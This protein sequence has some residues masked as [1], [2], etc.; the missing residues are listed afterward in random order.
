MGWARV[1]GATLSAT[2][3]TGAS[4]NLGNLG[5]TPAAGDTVLAVIGVSTIFAAGQY[6]VTSIADSGGHT[7]VLDLRRQKTYGTSYH[8]GLEVWRTVANGSAINSFTPTFSGSLTAV[9]GCAVAAG[10]YSGVDTTASAGGAVDISLAADG[11]GASSPADSGTTGSTT[12]AANELKIGAYSDSGN[13]RTLSAGSSDIAYSVFVKKDASGTEEA[14]LED[15][16]SGSSGST[17]RA[18][19]AY[20]GAAADWQM[21]VLVYKITAGGASLAIPVVTAQYRQRVA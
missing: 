6:S 3:N 11:T 19:L 9:G 15:G 14:A 1:V 16:D 13:N 12:A 5:A 8:N 17:A 10:A 21:A 4:P 2:G 7:W 18:T 20:S